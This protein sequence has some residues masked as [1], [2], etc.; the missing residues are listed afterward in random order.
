MSKNTYK[1][2]PYLIRLLTK[3]SLRVQFDTLPTVFRTIY[4]RL[5]PPHLKVTI[6]DSKDEV[7]RLLSI[8]I[9]NNL[10]NVKLS[11]QYTIDDFYFLYELLYSVSTHIAST[12]RHQ[13]V[14]IHYNKKRQA[15]NALKAF[16]TKLEAIFTSVKAE[17]DTL[18]YRA[19]DPVLSQ[20]SLVKNSYYYNLHK[21]PKDI[22]YLTIRRN[23]VKS[24]Q[25][26]KG[27]SIRTAYPVLEFFRNPPKQIIIGKDKMDNAIP[28][29]LYI[30]NH[31][32]HRLRH[33]IGPDFINNFY[34]SILVSCRKQNIIQNTKYS[35]LMEFY[36]NSIK[37]G[38]FA[39]TVEKNIALIRSFKFI[40]MVGT[41]E[42]DML[43]RYMPTGSD[44]WQYLHLDSYDTIINSDIKNRPELYQIF[45][46][47]NLEYLFDHSKDD[48]IAIADILSSYIVAE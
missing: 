34:E 35:Y 39:L 40:T 15:I 6:E 12:I 24:K 44:I 21:D 32:I 9:E 20:I 23:I 8:Q 26:T 3:S 36:A 13:D 31:A 17:Y 37:L 29:P 5:N 28:L 41:P 38:Y 48:S 2:N 19:V 1:V 10:R 11:G 27:A 7:A 25:V 14:N 46:K 42:Y 47:C 43:K 45:Q 4:H 18:F 33:R 22:I 16:H 30:Q